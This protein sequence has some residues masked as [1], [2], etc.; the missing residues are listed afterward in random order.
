MN[1]VEKVGKYGTLREKILKFE[2]MNEL[3]EVGIDIIG[4]EFTKF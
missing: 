2:T 1:E 4:V 3:E